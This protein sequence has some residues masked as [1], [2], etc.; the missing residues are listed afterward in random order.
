MV[1]NFV[2][3]AIGGLTNFLLPRFLS[4]ESYANIK[5]YALYISYAGFFSLGYNDGMYLKYGGKSI[6]DIRQQL[7]RNYFNYIIVELL[8]LAVSFTVSIVL[9]IIFF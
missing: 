2:S 9:K 1:A 3:L 4:I 8:M 5:T 7:G 6:N